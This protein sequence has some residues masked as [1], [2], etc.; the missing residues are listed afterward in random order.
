MNSCAD[1]SGSEPSRSLD[2]FSL[3]REVQ[4]KPFD[5]FDEFVRAGTARLSRTAFLLTG[6][7]HLAQDLLQVA[8][9]RVASRWPRLRDG[10]PEAY[11][12]RVM[13]NEFTSWRRRRRYHEKPSDNL[14]DAPAGADIATV[15][16]RRLV[17][18]RALARLG[19]RQRAVLVLRFYEDLSEVETAELLGCSVGT[20]KSQ[21]HNALARLRALAPELAE[22]VTDTD[23]VLT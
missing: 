22:L 12:R 2:A 3:S 18:H 5:G 6:D 17:L 19:P 1:L 7:H 8:L 16:V 15:A 21:T 10:V 14:Q 23:E 20:V 13:V 9:T 11:A 4:V